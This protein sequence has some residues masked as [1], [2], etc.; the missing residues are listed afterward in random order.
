MSKKLK[1]TRFRNLTKGR[2]VKHQNSINN[3]LT[4]LPSG[5]KSLSDDEKE[6]FSCL[7]ECYRDLL[8]TWSYRSKQLIQNVEE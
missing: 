5:V 8:G 3:L 6:K 1:L 7:R 2:L 4:S